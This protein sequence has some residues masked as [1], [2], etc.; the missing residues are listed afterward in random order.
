MLT[1]GD[2]IQDA[3]MSKSRSSATISRIF[4]VDDVPLDL[5][6]CDT[7]A[8]RKTVDRRSSMSLQAVDPPRHALSDLRKIAFTENYHPFAVDWRFLPDEI[9]LIKDYL[10]HCLTNISNYMAEAPELTPLWV[11]TFGRNPLKAVQSAETL[12][13]H[14]SKTGGTSISK[15]L[16]GKNLPPYSARFWLETFGPAVRKLRSF[17][18]IRHPV[19]RVVSA[20]KMVLAGGTDIMAYSR[21]SRYNMKGLESLDSFIDYIERQKSENG[22]LSLE[23]REQVTSILDKNDEVLV[24]RLFLLDKQHGFPKELSLWLSIA[25]IPHLNATNPNPVFVSKETREKIL[26]IYARDLEI[27]EILASKGGFADLRGGRFGKW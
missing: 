23:L 22:H 13:I 5:S 18:V 10:R 4:G 9:L 8:V 3:P 6:S 12:F 2:R 16:Y 20:Y 14:I 1:N 25:Q 27:Y 15:V 26:K 21:F 17:S 19:D 11:N 24:D 7:L